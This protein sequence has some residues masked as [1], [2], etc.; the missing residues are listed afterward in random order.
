MAGVMVGQPFDTIKVRMQTQ[1]QLATTT[2]FRSPL[3]CV[4]HTFVNAGIKGMYRGMGYPLLAVGAQKSMA[5]GVY[6]TIVQ[7]LQGQKSR[8]SLS[9]VC[10]AGMMGGAANSLIL[11]PV[12]Q[13]KIAMQI[14]RYDATTNGMKRLSMIDT[15]RTI[16]R[17]QG[18]VHGVYGN[19][20]ATLL[21]ELAMYSVYYTLYAHLTHTYKDHPSSLAHPS[22]SKLLMGGL[23]GVGCW[24]SCYPLDVLKSTMVAQTALNIPKAE[25]KSIPGMIKHMYN[26]NGISGFYRG[27]QPALLRAFP[28]HATV[29]FT[30]DCLIRWSEWK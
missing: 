26:T 14:Q 1:T 21:R 23:T 5:F 2:L 6:G 19:L 10:I 20:K 7:H 25:R 12:D 24:A 17:E 29:F 15:A 18:I 11:T 9:E 28:V 8:P 27:L 3:E 22:L 30:Y 4:R 13:F 16:V